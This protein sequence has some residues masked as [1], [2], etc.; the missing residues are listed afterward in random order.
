[1]EL[2][3]K[4]LLLL[5]AVIAAAMLLF[6]WLGK[7]DQYYQGVIASGGFESKQ[8]FKVIF[9]DHQESGLDFRTTVCMQLTNVDTNKRW[10][11][12]ADLSKKHVKLV[13]RAQSF[14]QSSHCLGVQSAVIV[15]QDD[16]LDDEP[17]SWELLPLENRTKRLMLLAGSI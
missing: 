13:A 9:H 1:M 8:E 16:W 11:K 3:K 5:I 17:Y 14:R 4:F 2:A 12:F 10:T 6:T 7:H 15:L